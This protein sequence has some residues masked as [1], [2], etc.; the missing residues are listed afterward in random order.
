MRNAFQK[1][2]ELVE[3]NLVMDRIAHRPRGFAFVRY[4]SDEESKKAIE[5]MHGKF[6]DG[7]V[8][9]VEVSK[10]KSELRQELKETPQMQ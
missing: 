9:F 8:I 10:S 4:S 1:F 3:V 5:E 2:G 7:R 6:L